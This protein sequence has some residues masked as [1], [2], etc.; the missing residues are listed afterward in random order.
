MITKYEQ[1]R[2]CWDTVA[3]LFENFKTEQIYGNTLYQ[4]SKWTSIYSN[5]LKSG[6]K[7][8]KGIPL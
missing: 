1:K 4:K 3:E 2:N 8:R 6:Y 5:L 7:K